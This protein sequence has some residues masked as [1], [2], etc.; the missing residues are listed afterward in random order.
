MA[1][2]AASGM[3]W[4]WMPFGRKSTRV[5]SIGG[6]RAQSSIGI[7]HHES[8]R[9]GGNRRTEDIVDK[10]PVTFLAKNTVHTRVMADDDI[11]IGGGDTRPGHVCLRHT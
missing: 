1:C 2:L 8:G 4:G 3:A 9:R 10:A 11:V 5:G 6:D 7:D